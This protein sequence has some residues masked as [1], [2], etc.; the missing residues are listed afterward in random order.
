[1]QPVLPQCEESAEHEELSDDS[2]SSDDSYALDDPTMSFDPSLTSPIIP[3][4]PSI[5]ALERFPVPE[6]L[7]RLS[8]SRASRKRYDDFRFEAARLSSF[9]NWPV[10]CIDPASLAAAGFYYTGKL[11]RVRCFVCRVVIS[12]W[13][14]GRTPM[15]VH[16]IWSATCRF[17]RNE[18]CENVP[19]DTESISTDR[20]KSG[21]Y[22]LEYLSKEYSTHT[23]NGTA[24]ELLS[25]LGI[26]KAALP[27]YYQYITCA[28]RL[29][30]F[31]TWPVTHMKG[32]ELAEAGFFYS[33]V[34][35]RTICY[36]CGIKIDRWRPGDD[37]WR[38]HAY[39][40]SSCY[41]LLVT[42]GCEYINNVKGEQFYATAA[43]APT[44]VKFDNH[45]K[46]TSENETNEKTL[47]EK[48]ADLEGKNKKLKNSRSC[49][50]CTE[51]EVLV[52]CCLL[53][54]NIGGK[55]VEKNA[56]CLICDADYSDGKR[57]VE[58]RREEQ[59]RR[60]S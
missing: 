8:T 5:S 6:S 48:V 56:A 36:Q 42:R 46:P 1:M 4:E 16:E 19:I 21:R 37:I 28:S 39:Y 49:K 15:Q 14:K 31:E 27:E 10:S 3:E 11:D 41:Y 60:V 53:T 24:Y 20:M 44:Q 12:H 26:K 25:R 38:Q 23:E 55:P 50:V 32:E 35:E 33:G 2:I 52:A 13:L 45:V 17:V 59:T 18:N 47:V 22:G 51:R 58:K 43:E 9:R 30:T 29:S 57:R 54:P 40:S 7:L 34:G